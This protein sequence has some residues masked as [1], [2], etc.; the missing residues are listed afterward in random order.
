MGTSK[1]SHPSLKNIFSFIIHFL[2]LIVQ[3]LFTNKLSPFTS[4]TSTPIFCMSVQS[5][6]ISFPF[7]NHPPTFEPGS[8]ID[9]TLYSSVSIFKS[10]ISPSFVPVLISITSMDFIAFIECDGKSIFS[11]LSIV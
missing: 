2:G 11:H 6:S 4:I 7:E 1:P 8:I 3:S 10:L 5:I 9:I